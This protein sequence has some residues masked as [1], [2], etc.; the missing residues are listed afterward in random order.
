M[1]Y[2]LSNLQSVAECDELAAIVSRERRGLENR[3]ES[4]EIRNENFQESSSDFEADMAKITSELSYLTSVIPN[5]PEGDKKEGL[6]T[7]QLVLTV[8]QRQLNARRAN[9]GAIGLLQRELDI[10]LLDNSITVYNSL[11]DAINAHKATL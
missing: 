11:I 10:E 3:K 6:I 5:M 7:D 2:T 9:Y 4:L 8:R 1:A